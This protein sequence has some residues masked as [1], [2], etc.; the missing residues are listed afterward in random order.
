M[1]YGPRIGKMAEVPKLPETI[2]RDDRFSIIRKSPRDMPIPPPIPGPLN[3]NPNL[4]DDHQYDDYLMKMVSVDGGKNWIEAV[5]IT[6]EIRKV[7]FDQKTLYQ[8]I[9]HYSD[10]QGVAFGEPAPT[11]EQAAWG[12]IFKRMK[13]RE[14][15]S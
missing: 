12:I 11:A 7:R 6:I 1:Q 8:P 10:M 5:R 4:H 15:L 14:Q 3:A 9:L 13:A 2:V